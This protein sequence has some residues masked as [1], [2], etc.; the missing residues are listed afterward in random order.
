MTELVSVLLIWICQQLGTEP[1]AAPGIEFVSQRQLVET[2][3][4]PNAPADA[5]VT[6]V[7][8]RTTRTV[9]LGAS[10]QIANLADR[11]TL[12]HELV[13]HVQ[14]SRALPYPCL[15]ARERDAYHLQ[16]AWL[17]QQGVSDPFGF[18][19]INEFTILSL[20]RCARTSSRRPAALERERVGTGAYPYPLDLDQSRL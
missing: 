20:R 1:P 18:I 17:E 13:H 11:S 5:S 3:F 9:L 6:A 16:A 8:S 4:G 12:L 15:A 7:Y 19:G 10:W 14:E 2:A